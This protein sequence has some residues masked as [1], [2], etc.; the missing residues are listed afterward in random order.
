MHSRT[1]AITHRDLKIE[2]VLLCNGVF[3]L[4]DFGSATTRIIEAGCG[5]GNQDIIKI[6]EEVS[7]LT[8][9]QYRAPEMCDLYQKRGLNEKVDIWALGVLLFKLCYYV[10]RINQTTPFEDSGKMAI[11]N[12]K[13]DFPGFP[14]YS[15]DLKDIVSMLL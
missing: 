3:K 15:Q 11:L 1:P 13:F 9:L 10:S 8:T 5:L 2:N 12:G 6:E 7:K 4:T 14:N